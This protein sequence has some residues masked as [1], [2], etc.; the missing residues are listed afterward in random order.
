MTDEYVEPRASNIPRVGT[1]PLSW[2]YIFDEQQIPAAST[3]SMDP[4]ATDWLSNDQNTIGG[5]MVGGEPCVGY[6]ETYVINAVGAGGGALIL[7]RRF[8][9]SLGNYYNIKDD[10][11]SVGVGPAG[12]STVSLNPITALMLPAMTFQYQ[13]V[14]TFGG[15][16]TLNGALTLRAR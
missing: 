15:V 10:S 14:S 4:I 1:F 2:T 3:W 7:R 5:L 8:L 11:L 13:I 16:V 6:L 9:S 12:S